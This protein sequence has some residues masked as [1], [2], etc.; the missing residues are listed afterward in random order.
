M[1][2]GAY[3]VSE[4]AAGV[5]DLDSWPVWTGS[6]LNEMAGGVSVS[7]VTSMA[8]VAAMPSSA[9]HLVG[10]P[11]R[12]FVVTDAAGGPLEDAFLTLEGAAD[13]DWFGKAAAI[14]DFDGDGASDLAV[15]VPRDIYFGFD[16]PGHVSLYLGP[17]TAG[18]RSDTDADLMLRASPYPD[19]LGFT[20]DAG[21]LDGDGRDDVV[22]AAPFD[23]T[24]GE[25]AGAVHVYLG[26]NL[27]L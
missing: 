12:G 7:V 5:H 9:P 2:G 11:R 4:V 25:A 17:L 13:V 6:D 14:G 22:A 24:V 15:G 16:Q 18:T 10:A 1:R 26:A 8:T 23:E 19:A 3:L 27:A 20:L 21:D